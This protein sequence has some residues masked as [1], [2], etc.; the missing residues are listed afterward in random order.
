MLLIM[1]YSTGVLN[2]IYNCLHLHH[3]EL[4]QDDTIELLLGIL[5]EFDQSKTTQTNVT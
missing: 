2:K 1:Y 3:Q 5:Q 4:Y